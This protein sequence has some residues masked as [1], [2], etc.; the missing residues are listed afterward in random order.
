MLSPTILHSHKSRN[1][2]SHEICRIH[3]ILEAMKYGEFNG[4][5]ASANG[6]SV[7]HAKMFP[8]SDIAKS[9]LQRQTKIKY[10]I[11]Y[12]YIYGLVAHIKE[13]LRR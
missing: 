9:W 5:F 7:H 2:R 11:E 3:E 6:D 10:N 8:D 1:I 12:I 13:L 4:S